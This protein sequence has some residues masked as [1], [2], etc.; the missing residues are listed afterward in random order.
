MIHAIVFAVQI[1]AN[2]ANIQQVENVKLR[3]C[4]TGINNEE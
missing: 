1:H 4:S 3:L 2:D